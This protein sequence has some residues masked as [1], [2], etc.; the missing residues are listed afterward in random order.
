MGQKLHKGKTALPKTGEQRI[1]ISKVS[2]L[3]G[4]AE[5]W[6][7]RV[8]SDRFLNRKEQEDEKIAKKVTVHMAKKT[9]TKKPFV[10]TSKAQ[11]S[12]HN[13][14]VQTSLFLRVRIKERERE[15]ERERE[16]EREERER[17]RKK[18]I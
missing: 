9:V 8:R 2:C 14:A 5:R 16:S 6:Q 1:K 17:E 18:Y 12:M 3:C 11:R 10:I 15:R 7:L 4:R 13:V